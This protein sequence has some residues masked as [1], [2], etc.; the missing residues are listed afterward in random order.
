M[1]YMK[2]SSKVSIR[3]SAYVDDIWKAATKSDQVT[4]WW[5]GISSNETSTDDDSNVEKEANYD[6]VLYN[7]SLLHVSSYFT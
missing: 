5:Y 4:L 1:G 2:N 6:D 7:A 3:T